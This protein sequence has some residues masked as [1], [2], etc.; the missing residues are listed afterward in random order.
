M[1]T[2]DRKLL[3]LAEILKVENKISSAKEFCAI[4]EID[5][6]NFV[7]IKNGEN[8]PDQ[9]YHFTPLHIENACKKL[10]INA[11]WIF[12]QSKEIY[13]KKRSTKPSTLQSKTKEK[14]E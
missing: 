9:K 10:N 5:P 3:Q 11:A 12:D 4:L 2:S 14:P 6:G 8:Y 7:K 1:Y 13:L